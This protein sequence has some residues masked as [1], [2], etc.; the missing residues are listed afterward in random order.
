[1]N[2][3]K[4]SCLFV[5]LALV[6]SMFCVSAFA[7][8][9]DGNA[10]SDAAAPSEEAAAADAANNA[11]DDDASAD[12]NAGSDVASEEG[13]DATGTT[14]A[15]TD[16]SSAPVETSAVPENLE[17]VPDVTAE[18]GVLIVYKDDEGWAVSEAAY[19]ADEA[20]KPITVAVEPEYGDKHGSLTV[21]MQDDGSWVVTDASYYSTKLMIIPVIII[22]FLVTLALM[23]TINIIIIK[24][25]KSPRGK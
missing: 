6:I 22:T 5:V 23:V 7:L 4:F 10:N 11:S 17:F 14:A 15:G 19:Y 24:L 12:A 2:I 9:A 1:M 3:K 13:A 8:E 18:L 16:A 20:E 25:R 21:E